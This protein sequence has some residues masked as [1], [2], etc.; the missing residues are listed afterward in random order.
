MA[1]VQDP[2]TTTLGY[3]LFASAPTSATAQRAAAGRFSRMRVA[4]PFT[5]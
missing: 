3:A 5:G 4:V 1:K 2:T